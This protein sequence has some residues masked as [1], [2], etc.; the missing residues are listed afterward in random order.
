MNIHFISGLP[1]A[2]SSMLAA[3]LRQN[4]AF[5]A[6]MSGPVCGMVAALLRSMGAANEYS[7][8]LSDTQRQRIVSSVFDGYYGE[9][10]GKELIFDTNREWSA[11]LPMLSELFPQARVI[12]CV[13]SPA[14]ILDSVERRVQGSPFLRG[15]MFSA[16]TGDNVYARAEY[17][18]KKGLLAAPLQALRQAW[19]GEQAHRLIAMRYDSLT[20]QP[21]EVIGRLY[22]LLGQPPFPHDFDNL[23]YDE[24]EFDAQLGMPGLHRVSRRVA[25]NHRATILPPDLFN[26]ND[27]SFWDVPGQNP[28]GVTVL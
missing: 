25:P 21:A 18:L 26:Q 8:F 19:Y 11:H 27:R 14:W 1:R 17:M 16:E 6:A 22:E 2:G 12:C 24:P 3:I 5:H 28:R 15:K 10:P 20:A 23:E 9:L 7:R 13:R 4:P